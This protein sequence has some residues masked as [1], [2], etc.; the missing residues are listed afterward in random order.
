MSNTVVE[1]GNLLSLVDLH[2]ISALQEDQIES[3]EGYIQRCN[4]AMNLDGEPLVEDAIYDK[5]VQLLTKA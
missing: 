5:L 2:G 4:E 1:I 3:L